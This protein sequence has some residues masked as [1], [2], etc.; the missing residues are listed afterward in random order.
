V[1]KSHGLDRATE[2]ATKARAME[3]VIQLP[4]TDLQHSLRI[5]AHMERYLR[6]MHA[7][8]EASGD[9]RPQLRAVS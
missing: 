1:S 9:G 8:S 4:T 3:L 6:D 7:E 5:I 2:R